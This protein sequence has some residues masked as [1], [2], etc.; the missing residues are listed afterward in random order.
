MAL[1]LFNVVGR[2]S[3]ALPEPHPFR[4]ILSILLSRLLSPFTT[5]LPPRSTLPD[6]P[7]FSLPP[8]YSFAY[9]PAL[10]LFCILLQPSIPARLST[11]GRRALILPTLVF[12]A[13]A[14]YWWKVNPV[15]W[16][17]G[18]SFRM[19]IFGPDLMLKVLEWGLMDEKDRATKLSWVGFDDE[20]KQDVRDAARKTE[21]VRH[22]DTTDQDR[23]AKSP[24]EAVSTAVPADKLKARLRNLDA[25]PRTVSSTASSATNSPP[26]LTNLVLNQLPTPQTSPPTTPVDPLAT[27]IQPK[28]LHASTHSKLAE[29]DVRTGSSKLQADSQKRHP[30]RVVVDACHFL[31][32][33]RGNGYSW[34][35][36]PPR[37]RSHHR[38]HHNLPRLSVAHFLRDQARD[39]VWGSFVSLVCGIYQTLHRDNEIVPF[40]ASHV[41]VLQSSP[42]VAALAENV[43]DA[44]AY[45]MVGVSLF[46]E[47]YVGF[48]GSALGITIASV[49]VN[50]GLDRFSPDVKWRWTFDSREY[51]PLFD[52]PFGKMGEGGVAAFWGH[53][54]HALFKSP[55]TSLGFVPVSKLARRLGLPKS[56]GRFLAVSVVF[57]LS[58]WMH[59][60]AFASA[61]YNAIPTPSG[62][63]YSAAL[64]IPTTSL[65][66][67]PWSLLSFRERYGTWVFFLAQPLAIALE[68]LY[69][70]GNKKKIGGWSGRLWTTA[71]VAGIGAY[72][73]G[74]SWLSLGLAHGVPP[75][76]LWSWARFVVPLAHLAPLPILINV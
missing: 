55:F 47:M 67:L 9:A 64:G 20:G 26:S 57:F 29:P 5:S 28:P 37:H 70:G 53:R 11:L 76:R 21:L 14:P 25:Q 59:V 45:I 66:P 48:S 51:A 41:P 16:S 73:V 35:P 61:R 39:F 36:P 50:S 43:V 23:R 69:L 49:V 63:A 10:L 13:V 2:A 56:T 71:W 18:F 8:L 60:Q 24:V 3:S 58:A 52:N 33:M 6:P 12:V 22:D 4:A 62:V 72:F 7:P 19:G 75:L 30:F 42:L 31:S 32:S 17:V 54:W 38:K 1:D 15:E 74:R 65:T 40:L 46:A 34:G 44:I 68:T 27:A